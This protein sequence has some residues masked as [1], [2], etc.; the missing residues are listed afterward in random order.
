M[1]GANILISTLE[2][3]GV[4]VVFGYPGGSVLPIYDALY[5]SKIKHILTRHEQGAAHAADGYARTTGK[6]GV[7]IATSGPG[8]TNLVTGIATAFLDSIPMLIITGQVNTGALGKDSFQ[9]ADTV[10]ITLPITKHSFLVKD[11]AELEHIIREA[12]YIATEGRPGPVLVDIPKD[13]ANS[14]LSKR[15]KSLQRNGKKQ[16][17][18]AGLQQQVARAV[19]LLETAKQPIVFIGGGAVIADAKEEL[20]TFINEWKLPVVQTL[21]GKGA[22]EE[23]NPL[24]LGM[25]GM[26]GLAPANLALAESDVVL[27]LG[28]RFDDR[29][30]GKIETFLPEAEI[31]HVDIDPAE[32]GKN[33][34]CKIPIVADIKDFLQCLNLCPKTVSS[35][36]WEKW[37]E[38]IALW[39]SKYSEVVEHNEGLKPFDIMLS[40]NLLDKEK[41]IVTTDVGQHQMWAAQYFKTK[42][43]RTFLSPG[44]L[45]TMGYGLP[46]AIGAAV[47]KPD[48]RV[49]VLSGDGSIQMN[50]QELATLMQYQLPITIAVFNN[51]SLGM[52]RQ[53]QGLFHGG[54]LSSSVFEYAPD[55]TAIAKAYGLRVIKVTKKEEVSLAW[56]EG[57]KEG[58]CL[59][60]FAI[61]PEEAVYPMVPPGGKIDEMVFGGGKA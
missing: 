50:I 49:V 43:N 19:D 46:A 40:L 53:W 48:K 41:I 39:K 2:D 14:V 13:V 30:T 61:N 18:T 17:I 57:F 42:Y 54:R 24:A 44:G 10:G 47:A 12:Y 15:Q 59:I 6:P 23:E 37:L 38:K 26:H 25:V 45:G 29:V 60:D 20:A 22:I 36:V 3:V 32:I 34:D 52:V 33:L 9:E 11:V 16:K 7:C 55:L 28:V 31:I 56:Q 27:A 51:A 5:D 1:L 4:D 8:A 58:P 35:D 21:M